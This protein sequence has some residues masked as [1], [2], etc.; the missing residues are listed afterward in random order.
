MWCVNHF[1]IKK[2]FGAQ[3]DV[4]AA[5][6][7]AMMTRAFDIEIPK[8]DSSVVN[9][10]YGAFGLPSSINLN[11]AKS[12]YTDIFVWAY[13]NKIISDEILPD[14]ILS[15]ADFVEILLKVYESLSKIS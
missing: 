5:E 10:E 12:W 6:A 14:S 7:L 15:V 4:N 2:D 11:I 1:K 9:I 8:V 13:A 3:N